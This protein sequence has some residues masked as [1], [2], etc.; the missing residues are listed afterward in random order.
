M[1]DFQSVIVGIVAIVAIFSISLIIINE[2]MR[3]K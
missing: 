3:D 2:V 1:T